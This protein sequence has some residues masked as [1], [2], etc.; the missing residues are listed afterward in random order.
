MNNSEASLEKYSLNESEEE[1]E[2]EK[3]SL[4][5]TPV[6]LN[7]RQQQQRKAQINQTSKFSNKISSS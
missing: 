7:G 2:K 4:A 1:I 6:S 5:I 3:R